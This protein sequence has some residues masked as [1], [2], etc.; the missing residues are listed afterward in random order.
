MLRLGPTAAC[1]TSR[2]LF[3]CSWQIAQEEPGD[4][5]DFPVGAETL[6]TPL[7]IDSPPSWNLWTWK[8][9][10]TVRSRYGTHTAVSA[11]RQREDRV[12][13]RTE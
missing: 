6:V 2:T 5:D 11:R 9:T 1:E 12:R 7:A 3:L 13:C 4:G 8:S 10:R